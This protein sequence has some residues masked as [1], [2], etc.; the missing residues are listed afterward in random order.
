MIHRRLE[1]AIRGALTSERRKV[2]VL[3]GP[4]Q[5]GKTTLLERLVEGLDGRV[6][7]LN[8]DFL[9]DQALLRPER[10]AL[11]RLVG[12]LDY[13]FID[14]A[15][16]VPDVG[17]VLKLLHDHHPQVRVLATGSSSFDLNERVGE[18]LTGRRQTFVMH[19]VSYGE[20]EPR[21]T[22]ESGVLEH[23][24]LFGGYPEVLTIADRETKIAHLRELVADYLLKDI[25]HLVG[26]G[27]ARLYDLLRLLALQLG[28]E[29][30][31][32]ELAQGAKL[33]AKTV[34][35]YLDLLEECYV[36]VQLQGFSRNL[37]KEIRKARKI[38]FVD[39]GIRN[40]ILQAFGPLEMR[41]DLGGLREN[42][43][44]VERMKRNA[45]AGI[46]ARYHFWRTYDQQEIDLIEEDQTGLH[47]FEFKLGRGRDS[48]PKLWRETYPESSTEVITKASL[49]EFLRVPE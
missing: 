31:L 37:R 4:R 40:A 1:P 41:N 49:G 33:D 21:P 45:Q 47:A 34:A 9:D 12:G 44:I 27:R 10:A 18:P 22:T 2:V 11:A 25:L 30:S 42:Y 28:S 15:Q 24:L 23:G 14:E 29:A 39:L 20:L 43:L 36:I 19:P 48:V 32:S 7:V 5:V 16:N 6:E 35:R 17:R 46:D 3:Q 13:L 38:Y 8:G 26:T